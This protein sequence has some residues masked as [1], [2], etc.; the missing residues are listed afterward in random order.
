[1]EFETDSPMKRLKLGSLVISD[2]VSNYEYDGLYY[3]T[4]TLVATYQTDFKIDSESIELFFDI[5]PE[6]KEKDGVDFMITFAHL[7][8]IRIEY[9]ALVYDDIESCELVTLEKNEDNEFTS[10]TT[11]DIEEIAIDPKTGKTILKISDLSFA[12]DFELRYQ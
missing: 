5:N 2:L 6:L 1:M 9:F 11:M 7:M 12:G 10:E 4:T 8:G 3:E